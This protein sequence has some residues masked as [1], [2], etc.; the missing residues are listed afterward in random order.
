MRSKKM[1]YCIYRIMFYSSKSRRK[2]VIQNSSLSATL[3]T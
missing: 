2:V 1:Q 3:S